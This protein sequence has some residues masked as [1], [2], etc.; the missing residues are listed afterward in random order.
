M[1][2]IVLVEFLSHFKAKRAPDSL[3]EV[4]IAT[5]DKLWHRHGMYQTK[6]AVDRVGIIQSHSSE[7]AI[8]HQWNEWIELHSFER[9]LAASFILESNQALLLV[10][11]SHSSAGLDLLI[12]VAT[13]LWDA[14]SSTRW[15]ALLRAHPIPVMNIFQTLEEIGCN[16]KIHCD[17]FQSALIVACYASSTTLQLQD[18]MDCMTGPT[19]AMFEPSNHSLLSRALAPQSSVLIMHH[20]VHLISCTPLRALIA[21]SGET[22]FFSQK[23]AGDAETAAA[24]FERLQLQ[25]RAWTNLTAPSAPSSSFGIPPTNTPFADAVSSA[26][27]ILKLATTTSLPHSTLAFGPEMAIYFAALVLWAATYAAII[28]AEANGS[29]FP[30]DDETAEFEPPRAEELVK[31]WLPL[32][33]ADVNASTSSDNPALPLCIPPVAVLDS[34]RVGVGGVVRWTAWVLGGAGQRASGAGELVEGAVGVLEKLGR[35]GFVASE[36]WF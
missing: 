4:F 12:P 27:A 31:Q 7:E 1:Q 9:L 17:P 22:W 16:S 36:S 21:T 25:L 6:S 24:E 20:A 2:A 35:S 30:Q 15:S 26:L 19:H 10:R 13:A 5:Y 23:L 14:P 29:T 28:R 34:W 11:P 8:R 3:S 32:A 33:V 18:T